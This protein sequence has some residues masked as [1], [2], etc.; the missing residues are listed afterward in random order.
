MG[1]VVG[2]FSSEQIWTVCLYLCVCADV[3]VKVEDKMDTVM[4]SEHEKL[5]KLIKHVHTICQLIRAD[6]QQRSLVKRLIKCYCFFLAFL[7]RGLTLLQ[8][9]SATCCMFP[10]RDTQLCF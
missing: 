9:W 10:K 3:W 7:A 8:H 1:L 5:K 6:V 4:N 2:S